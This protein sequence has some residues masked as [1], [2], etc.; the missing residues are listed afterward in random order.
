MDIQAEGSYFNTNLSVWE[1][2]LEPLVLTNG[3]LKTWSIEAKVCDCMT[4]Y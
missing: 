2:L 4:H 1:P 3:S